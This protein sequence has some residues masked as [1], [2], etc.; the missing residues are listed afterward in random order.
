MDAAHQP[1]EVSELTKL[2]QKLTAVSLPPDLFEKASSLIE[3][4]AL[5]LKY[6]AHLSGFD[7]VANYI[8]LINHLP[9]ENRSTDN[10][11]IAHAKE[12]L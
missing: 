7:A 9:W 1:T 5:G 2:K 4:V 3:R 6:G 12:I 11:D 8:D 10:L